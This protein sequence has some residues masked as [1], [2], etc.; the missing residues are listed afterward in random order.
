MTVGV[1]KESESLAQSPRNGVLNE[2]GSVGGLVSP[3]VVDMGSLP[4]P[5]ASSV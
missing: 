1:A 3:C 5:I 4:M 2:V